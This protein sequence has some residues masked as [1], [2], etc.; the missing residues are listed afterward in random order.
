[1]NKKRYHLKNSKT[2]NYTEK[3]IELK[4]VKKKRNKD[5]L[6]SETELKKRRNNKPMS[7]IKVIWFDSIVLLYFVII[8]SYS[9]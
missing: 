1:M 3:K 5:G 4:I 9:W 8:S 2:Q 6:F 7:E